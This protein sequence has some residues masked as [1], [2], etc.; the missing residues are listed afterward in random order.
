M[1]Y[2]GP[3]SWAS[4]KQSSVSTSSAESEYI[5]QAMYAKQGQW[6]AQIFRDISMP[7]CINRNRTTV[8]MYG[9]NQGAIALTKNPHLNERSKHIDVSYHFIRDLVEKERLK[10]TYVPTN[11]M[12]TDGSTK[13]LGRVAFEKFKRQMGVVSES[14]L[15]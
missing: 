5:S 1:F 2:G 6:T 15:P 4:K 12:I 9:D 11:E 3:Y 7:E 14:D 13:P 10:I 8:Q